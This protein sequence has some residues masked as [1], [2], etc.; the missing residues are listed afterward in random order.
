MRKRAL[1]A[2]AASAMLGAVAA[3]SA[4]A[5]DE[6]CEA[7]PPVQ[8]VTPGGAKVVVF[9]V[10][11]GPQEYRDLLKRPS[12]DYTAVR[13]K[14]GGTQVSLRVVI[15]TGDV[16]FPVHS[17]VWMTAAQDGSPLSEVLG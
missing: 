15:P 16:Q 7:D 3:G 10:D 13:A 8:I 1:L 6:W 2:A 9:V 14:G 5:S 4:A 17:R 12:I 11:A